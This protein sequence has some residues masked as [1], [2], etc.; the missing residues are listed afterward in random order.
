MKTRIFPFILAILFISSCSLNYKLAKQPQKFDATRSAY[1]PVKKDMSGEK[2]S[3]ETKSGPLPSL[4]FNDE[5]DQKTILPHWK[6]SLYWCGP[7]FNESDTEG[8][9]YAQD[10]FTFTDSTVRLWTRY[11]P[12]TFWNTKTNDSVTIKY[13]IGLLDLI[14]WVEGGGNDLIN[15][16]SVECRAK[17]PDGKQEWPAFWICGYK[18]WPPEVDI[19]EFW[20]SEKGE[21]NNNFHYK[22]KDRN[23]QMP[24]SFQIPPDQRDDFHIYRLDVKEDRFEFYFDNYLYRTI[25]KIGHHLDKFTVII[26]NGIHD[27]PDHDTFLELDWVRIYRL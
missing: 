12:K 9:Y 4:I 10:N 13:G 23:E 1:S 5:F 22:G 18:Q 26:N 21:F 16:F 6:K 8:G 14:P 24:K 19:F 3:V 20:K 27:S 7:L 25:P 11:Q 2:F 17:M 15:N